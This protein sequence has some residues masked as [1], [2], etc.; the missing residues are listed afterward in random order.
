MSDDFF[1]GYKGEA[2]EVLKKGGNAVDA[3][4]TKERHPGLVVG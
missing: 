1:Q 4:V 2:L 3:A